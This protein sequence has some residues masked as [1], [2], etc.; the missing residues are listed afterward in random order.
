MYA[1]ANRCIP[2]GVNLLEQAQ[3]V[4]NFTT[5]EDILSLADQEMISNATFQ[6]LF[7]NVNIQDIIDGNL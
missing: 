2:T 4:F 6:D 1:V 3:D 7:L 5:P